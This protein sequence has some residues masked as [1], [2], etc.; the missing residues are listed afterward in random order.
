MPVY[1]R[2]KTTRIFSTEVVLVDII[3]FS[4]MSVDDQVTATVMI[5]GELEKYLSI[6]TGQSAFAIKE[7]VA[8]FVPTGDGFYV[9]LQPRLVGYG[10]LLA[11]SLRTMLLMGSQQCKNLLQGI[12]IG[13]HFGEIAPF[14]DITEK[15]NFVGPV[16]NN[17][18]RLL[19]AKSSQAPNGFLS[20][21]CFIIASTESVERFKINYKYDD[22]DSYFKKMGVKISNYIKVDDKHGTKHTGA[23]IE[24]SRVSAYNPP[25]PSDFKER[26]IKRLNRVM[27]GT[28]DIKPEE[29]ALDWPASLF[30]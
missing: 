8:G 27:P 21:D 28:G 2:N 3:D 20:D 26:V 1:E 7:V 24:G 19:N 22:D 15:Q 6:S 14:E 13:V 5:N 18:A 23:F 30:P 11:L 17:C 25:R 9:V 16:M 10:L 4:C 12:R 29:L